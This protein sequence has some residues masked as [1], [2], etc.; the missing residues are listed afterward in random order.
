LVTYRHNWGEDRVYFH[1][2]SGLLRSIPACWTTVV[3][4]DPFV[5]LAAGR[6]L[7]RH[8]DL[9]KLADLLEKAR[10]LERLE[11]KDNNAAH[12]ITIMP[13]P[14]CDLLRQLAIICIIHP[15]STS[16]RSH[17]ELDT[18]PEKSI[19]ILTEIAEGLSA[20][21]GRSGHQTPDAPTTGNAEPAPESRTR[22]AVSPKRFL[23]SSRSGRC[24][25]R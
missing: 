20:A 15:K 1:D 21:N 25:L 9:L 5:V 2:G 17:K 23:R 24:G 7:F 11:C 6:C 14:F 10:C 3:V 22:R 13:K 4:A 18:E 12:V 19:I 8:E 16:H